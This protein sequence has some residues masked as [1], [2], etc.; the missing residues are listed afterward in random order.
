VGI[1]F[2]VIIP[3]NP[4]QACIPDNTFTFELKIPTDIVDRVAE[5]LSHRAAMVAKLGRSA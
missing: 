1:E 2:P 3:K 4:V 5:G